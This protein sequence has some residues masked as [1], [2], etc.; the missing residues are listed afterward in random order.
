VYQFQAKY[1]AYIFSIKMK[2]LFLKIGENSKPAILRE[3]LNAGIITG[4][5]V[6]V[7]GIAIG[8]IL[9]I[10]RLSL[11]MTQEEIADRQSLTQEQISR[12]ENGKSHNY[13]IIEPLC[14]FYGITFPP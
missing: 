10:A 4:I 12:V 3:L 7:E 14:R 9:K 13:R 11:G 8:E 1:L 6:D 2:K 5:E